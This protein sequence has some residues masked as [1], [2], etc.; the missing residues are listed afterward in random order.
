M[1][2]WYISSSYRAAN[3]Q[4]L[5]AS[6]D[7]EGDEPVE[8]DLKI[9]N[10]NLIGV[11]YTAKLAIHYLAR[12]KEGS[13]RCLIMTSSLA[14][15]LD[16]PGSPQYN[17]AKFGVRGLMRALRR[18]GSA[19][20]M[21]VNIIAPWFVRTPIIADPV[22]DLLESKGIKFAEKADVG[23]AVLHIASDRSMNGRSK[24]CNPENFFARSTLMHSP[25]AA[26]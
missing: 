24:N 22:Q 14:G 21:R 16:L 12:N 19:T 4:S 25:Q 8:P 26:L 7:A 2:E 17:A 5:T 18:T 9:I 20:N 6:A 3:E 1:A 11:S 15:Y 23:A 13:D 10:I